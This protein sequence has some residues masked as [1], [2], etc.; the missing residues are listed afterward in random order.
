MITK[1]LTLKN[2]F[3]LNMKQQP[4]DGKLKDLKQEGK[5]SLALSNDNKID[6]AGPLD[7][8]TSS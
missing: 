3:L 1:S 5:V 4:R 6:L 8:L 7:P 2:I